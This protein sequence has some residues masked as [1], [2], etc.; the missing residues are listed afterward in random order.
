MTLHHLL[1]DM[2]AVRIEKRVIFVFLYLISLHGAQNQKLPALI[3]LEKDSNVPGTSSPQLK[4]VGGD[5]YG[6]EYEPSLVYCFLKEDDLWECEGYLD[7][8]V[9]FGAFEVS[10]LGD[11]YQAPNN[12]SCK[13]EYYLDFADD[14]PIDEGSFT[15]SFLT[16]MLCVVIMIFIF[17]QRR[18]PV[19]QNGPSPPGGSRL[20]QH[21]GTIT[22][23]RVLQ[24][25][26]YSIIAII[27]FA[28]LLFM[29]LIAFMLTTVTLTG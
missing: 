21:H 5:A 13:M 11:E 19:Q 10:C 2:I 6:T 1:R 29:T 28:T 3:K 25:L 15:G 17:R 7:S 20:Q 23:P 8:F 12:H 4:C 22:T 16:I 24:I 26:A 14:G 18:P 9:T 27:V